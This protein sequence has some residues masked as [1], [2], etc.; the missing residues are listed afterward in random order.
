[1]NDH[2]PIPLRMAAPLSVNLANHYWKIGNDDAQ[3]YSSARNVMVPLDDE[4]YA[5]WAAGMWVTPIGSEQELATVLRDGGLPLP[6]WL[7]AAPSFIQPAE[8][9]Y[10]KDQL[11]AYALTEHDR[12]ASGG[13]TLSSGL[14]IKT[15]L[16]TQVRALT[17]RAQ[18]DR[19]QHVW[20]NWLGE[21]GAVHRLDDAAIISLSDEL[22][23]FLNE[24]A[25]ALADVL[26]KI[27]SGA[28]T[29]LDQVNA[30]FG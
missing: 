2:D 6:E 3:V 24:A 13:M 1:M 10:T 12:V 30:A 17:L 4:A 26:A 28:V 21:D 29:K 22:A 5:A 7:F 23:A 9:H 8:G 11:H 20:V 27:R 14:K 16:A 15:D 19:G 25:D 18:V